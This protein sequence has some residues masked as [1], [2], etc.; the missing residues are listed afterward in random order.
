M[1]AVRSGLGSDIVET[2][3]VCQENHCSGHDSEF[4]TLNQEQMTALSFR[5]SRVL[6]GLA[7]VAA[8]AAEMC[9]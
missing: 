6:E 5:V 4:I 7:T 8:I 1:R 9:E 2:E 3:G